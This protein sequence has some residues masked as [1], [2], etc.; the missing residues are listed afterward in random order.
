MIFA[1]AIFWPDDVNQE[2][3]REDRVFFSYGIGEGPN[4]LY[5]QPGEG[6]ALFGTEKKYFMSLLFYIY[7]QSFQSRLILII[8]RC[9]KICILK[10]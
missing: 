4:L 7:K 8:Y 3:V 10:S 1:R 6:T 2:N 5:S 9:R